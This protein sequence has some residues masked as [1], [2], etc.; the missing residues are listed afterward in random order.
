MP[1]GSNTSG[2]CRQRPDQ[3]DLGLRIAGDWRARIDSAV[4]LARRSRCAIVVAG[5]E[6]GEFRDRAFLGLPGH[7]EELIRS[8]AAGPATPV[9]VVLIGG[10]AITMT[11]WLDRWRRCSDAGIPERREDRRSPRSCS[12]TSIPPAGC[13][14]AFPLAE[15]QLPLTYDHEPTGRGDDYVDL[16]GLPLF[17]V[18]VRAELHQLRIFGADHRAGGDRLREQSPWFAAG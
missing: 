13:R 9:T 18:R 4:A 10:S 12:A 15:G 11:S 8:V 5:I 1:S 17:P 14:S 6:E 3:V 7:Q 2:D 16:T